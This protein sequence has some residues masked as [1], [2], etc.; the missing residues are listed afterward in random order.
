MKPTRRRLTLRPGGDGSPP[1]EAGGREYRSHSR[2]SPR[3]RDVADRAAEKKRKQE[4]EAKVA[5]LA[6][7]GSLDYDLRR[8]EAAKDLD[9]PV[10]RLDKH[11][12]YKRETAKPGFAPPEIEP[13]DEP[14]S[15]V[16][17]LNDIAAA[18][19]RHVGVPTRGEE[20]IALW[21]MFAHCFGAAN[22]APRLAI[23]S[24]LP[25]CGKTTTL[26]LIDCLVPRSLL[27]SSITSAAVYRGI[28]KWHPTLI[29]DEADT[30]LPT[31]DTLRGILNSGHKK[32]GAYTVLTV[33]AT[34]SLFECR[35]GAPWP[36][37]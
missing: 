13:W 19:R 8:K 14:V 24:P 10:G 28:E 2:V 20:A 4:A 32:A 18:V 12:E 1:Q 9:L 29:I 27:A 36:S 35:H 22:I 17:V 34:M 21:V 16:D 5:E 30:F 11:V 23:T 26:E 3:H 7:L 6:K 25:E 31:N 15:G 33:G 37:P